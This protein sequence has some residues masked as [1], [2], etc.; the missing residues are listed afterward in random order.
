M[1]IR[2][3]TGYTIDIDGISLGE[4]L[5]KIN[6]LIEEYGESACIE[7]TEDMYEDY[8]YLKVFTYCE[9]TEEE[10]SFRLEKEKIS[11]DITE[12]YRRGQW[13]KLKKE[14]GE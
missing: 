6:N 1:K 12:S 13:E 9:E 2:K 5:M 10:K 8:S 4:V 7:E 11:K 3:S 14:F